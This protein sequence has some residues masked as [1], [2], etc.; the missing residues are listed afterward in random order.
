MCTVRWLIVSPYLIVSQACPPR[1]TTHA[2]LE[3]P[4]MPP[5]AATHAPEQPRMPPWSNHA[6]PPEQ[7]CTPTQE[8]PHM[9][10]EQPCMPPSRATMHA[11]PEQPHM[12]A[13]SPRSNHAPSPP[14]T[15]WQTGVKILP[16]PKLRL[17]EVTRKHSSRIRTAHLRCSGWVGM[18]SLA[19]WSHIFS[20]GS[21]A[22]RIWFPGALGGLTL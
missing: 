8:Q 12:P 21:L 18:M 17:R 6:H 3:Q 15:E 7:P 19:V 4:C 13:P 5:R 20:R 10:P 1:A 9:S 16:C 11:P 22:P 14:W 2:T